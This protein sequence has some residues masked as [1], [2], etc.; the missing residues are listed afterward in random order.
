MLSIYTHIKQAHCWNWKQF[1]ICSTNMTNFIVNKIIVN[2]HSKPKWDIQWA[3]KRRTNTQWTN[4]DNRDQ[5]PRGTHYSA[6]SRAIVHHSAIQRESQATI[7][8]TVGN[9]SFCQYPWN[10]PHYTHKLRYLIT[11]RKIK[12]LLFEVQ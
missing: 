12:K 4:M 8:V 5:E 6:R 7:Y 3:N 2:W 1:I 10:S 9:R 11:I